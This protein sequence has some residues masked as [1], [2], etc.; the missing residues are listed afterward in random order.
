MFNVGPNETTYFAFS[1]PFSYEDTMN[2]MDDLELMA[3]ENPNVYFNRETVYYSIEGRKMELITIS[4][5][6]GITEERET[7]P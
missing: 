5:M 3:K 4:S 1:P 6:D 7:V 2:K